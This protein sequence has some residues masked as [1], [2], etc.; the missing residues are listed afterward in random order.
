MMPSMIVVKGFQF[1]FH[2]LSLAIM[3]KCFTQVLGVETEERDIAI[4]VKNVHS[5]LKDR[6]KVDVLLC[7]LRAIIRSLSLDL[8]G[9]VW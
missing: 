7:F 9:D 4:L 5:P 1:F 8:E 6:C 2:S 3:R